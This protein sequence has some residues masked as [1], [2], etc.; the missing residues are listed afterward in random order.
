MQI[1]T[2]PKL[3]PPLA[4][5]WQ[6]PQPGPAPRTGATAVQ[7]SSMSVQELRKIVAELIG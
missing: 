6:G 4:L 3:L 1:V 5:L 7:R 2:R